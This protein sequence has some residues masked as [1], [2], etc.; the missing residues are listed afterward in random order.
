MKLSLRKTYKID[1]IGDIR[2]NNIEHYDIQ[3]AA[4]RTIFE[5]PLNICLVQVLPHILGFI[6]NKT[7]VLSGL[8]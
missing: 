1:F 3:Y 8:Q 2:T 5:A 7:I 6:H 4:D